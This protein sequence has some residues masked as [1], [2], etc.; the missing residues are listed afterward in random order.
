LSTDA[1]KI[2]PPEPLPS[3]P[4]AARGAASWLD[5]A[6]GRIRTSDPRLRRPPLFH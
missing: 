3:Q 5:D 1:K 6:P 4:N 2:S